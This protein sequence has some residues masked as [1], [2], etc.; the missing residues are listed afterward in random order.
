MNHP[1]LLKLPENRARRNYSGGA[2]IDMLKRKPVCQDGRQPEEWMA[3]TVTATNPGMD[4]VEKEG[5]AFIVDAAGRKRWLTDL[6]QES[7][8]FYLGAAHFQNYGPHTGFL[9]K[10]LDSAIRLH[11]QAHPSRAYAQ[12][13]LNSRWGKLECYAILGVRPGYEPYIRLG[14]QRPPSRAEWL[15]I[16]E[17]QDIRAMDACFDR[18]PV[19]PGEVWY[20]PGG[21]PHAIGEGVLMLEVMEP[22]DLVIRCEFEREG[23]VVPPQARFMGKD[24]ASSLDIFD[25]TAYSVEE[26]TRKFRLTPRVLEETAEYRW[27][28][29]TDKTITDSFAIEKLTLQPNGTFTSSQEGRFALLLVTQGVVK[30]RTGAEEVLLGQ[31]ESCFAAAGADTMVLE[32]L[33]M[34][35]AQVCVIRP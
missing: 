1:A 27:E 11:V 13:H 20:V 16:M 21:L 9:A 34:A 32:S 14:F 33:D 26:V 4:P 22:S 25:Y 31:G 35:P 15:R 17:Q 23:I 19:R 5:M 28:Q 18:V 8:E 3:S 10:L 29:Q 24:A 2:A 7:P 12:R 6:F 30:I